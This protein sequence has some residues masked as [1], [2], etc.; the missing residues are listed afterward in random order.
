MKLLEQFDRTQHYAQIEQARP[1]EFAFALV[2]GEDVLVNHKPVKC[3]DFLN[4]TL[5]WKEGFP[6][7]SIYGYCFNGEIEREFT[8]L[9]IYDFGNI[10][11]NIAALN[12]VLPMDLEPCKVV[13]LGKAVLVTGDKFWMKSTVHMSFYTTVLR[14]L[15][16]DRH[17][18]ILEDIPCETWMADV[19][20]YIPQLPKILVDMPVDK[21]MGCAEPYEG[22]QEGTV[23]EFNG[24]ATACNTYKFRFNRYGEY[25]RGKLSQA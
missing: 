3:R 22:D 23:H 19:H 15:T 21:V 4:D 14:G 6:H 1:C 7:T 9:V 2:V 8:S 5:C 20:K 12:D 18:E 24:W 16:Y 13:N 10:E 17:I 11:E 25:I